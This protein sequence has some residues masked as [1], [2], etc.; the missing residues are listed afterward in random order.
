MRQA[1]KAKASA[2]ALFVYIVAISYIRAVVV[3]GGVGGVDGV[4][5]LTVRSQCCAAPARMAAILVLV[6]HLDV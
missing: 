5:G 1:T 6:D 2:L 4:M 3:V